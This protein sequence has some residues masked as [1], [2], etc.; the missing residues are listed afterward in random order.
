MSNKPPAEAPAG[1]N[2]GDIY[3]VLFKHKWLILCFFVMGILAAGAILIIKP[4]QYES[5]AKLY[6]QYVTDVK[7][8]TT[9]TGGDSTIHDTSS[10][11]ADIILTELEFLTS[12]DLADQVAE[13]VGPDKILARFGGGSDSNAAAAVILKGLLAEPAARSPSIIHI[14]FQHPDQDVARVVLSEI[15]DA[16]V[17]KSAEQHRTVGTSDEFLDQE[18]KR[19]REQLE[20]TEKDL[21]AAKSE[22]GIISSLED[23]RKGWNS[24]Y[25]QIN[26]ELL[27]AGT[28]LAVLHADSPG[29]VAPKSETSNTVATVGPADISNDVRDQYQ[30]VCTAL[31][32][33]KATY[34]DDLLKYPQGSDFLK[35]SQNQVDGL[36]ARKAKF[37]ELYPQIA[38]LSFPVIT[39]PGATANASGNGGDQMG[40]NQL[41]AMT[42]YLTERL[43]DIRKAQTNLEAREPHILELQHR[44]DIED[45]ALTRFNVSLDNTKM[46]ADQGTSD[47]IKITESPTP[48][49]KKWSKSAKKMVGMA[50]AGG[51]L[52]GIGLAFLIELVLDGTVKRPGEIEKKLHLPLFISIPDTHQNDRRPTRGLLGNGR[53]L[54]LRPTVGRSCLPSTA[55]TGIRHRPRL[56]PGTGAILSTGSM[57][58]CATVWW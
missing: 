12:L 43:G 36:E 32:R 3:F 15:I 41:A 17:D 48:A 39:S 2:I 47:G 31:A 57:R 4:A 49:V 29:Q 30:A 40:V 11:S 6:V 19:L 46:G 20:S 35:E 1:L 8:P 55:P 27:E 53:L 22:A 38:N 9:D 58:V 26:A 51:I 13:H 16:Y 34:S 28:K 14:T 33:A 10:G 37:E 18:T 21:S 7:T 56:L 5:E 45:A 54:R 23:T 25:D 52:G 24:Q 44:R 42:N 50:L